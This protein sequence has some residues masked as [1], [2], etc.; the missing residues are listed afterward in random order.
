[1]PWTS[2]AGPSPRWTTSS[3]VFV[4]LA[5]APSPVMPLAIQRQ[6]WATERDT[7]SNGNG[8]R[9]MLVRL[10]AA[11]PPEKPQLPPQPNAAVLF[12]RGTAAGRRPGR[13]NHG[14][15]V[16]RRPVAV[17]RGFGTGHAVASRSR[18]RAVQRADGG[19]PL[20][21]TLKQALNAVA[22]KNGP[23][24]STNKS[25]SPDPHAAG[26]VYLDGFVACVVL[27]ADVVDHRLVVRV[28][29]CF[30]IHHTLWTVSPDPDDPASPAAK[31]VSSQTE[32]VA[33]GR[34]R[35]NA[36]RNQTLAKHLFGL[37]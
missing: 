1:M 3:S 28:E 20:T 7:D 17:G 13:A 14:G 27:G 16:S 26:T 24:R 21:Q 18:W 10:K 15:R 32:V 36:G 11:H 29:P 34:F 8:I 12:Y 25:R 35:K 9:E 2:G 4:P 30:L 22:G 33:I 19:D 31:H 6:A 37:Y 5:D 23:F